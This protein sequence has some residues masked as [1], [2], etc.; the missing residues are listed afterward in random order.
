MRLFRNDFQRN[1]QHSI[2]TSDITKRNSNVHFILG[3]TVYAWPGLNVNLP[4]LVVGKW[5]SWFKKTSKISDKKPQ[6][7]HWYTSVAIL[8]EALSAYVTF[9]L[10]RPGKLNRE[11]NTENS[12]IPEISERRVSSKGSPK[13]SE[14]LS[15][16]FPVP[17]D[18]WPEISEILTEWKA[19]LE[20]SCDRLS[21]WIAWQLL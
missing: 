8:F 7:E 18:F 5:H 2:H 10:G 9:A 1:V 6:A 3:N 4:L 21:R 19:P 13:F 15:G 17:L 14:I 16:T 11:W 20:S 12:V